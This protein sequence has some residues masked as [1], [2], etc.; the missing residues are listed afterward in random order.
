M[1]ADKRKLSP[2][3]QKFVDA[4]LVSFNSAKA[5]REAGYSEHTARTQG[6]RLLTNA[7]IREEIRERTEMTPDEVRA[8]QADIARGNIMD[9][10]EADASGIR[11]K[12]TATD[13]DGNVTPNP[14]AKLIRRITQR[15]SRHVSPKGGETETTA[16]EIEMYSAADALTKIGEM[17][18]LY[19]QR[20]VV[21]NPDGTP[22][23]PPKIVNIY[24]PH[25]G[26]ERTLPTTGN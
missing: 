13:A 10:I 12:L 5:A 21:E 17:H 19:R 25:N 22:I 8:R 16:F 2:Q 7:D 24:I 9:L 1:A 26:R 4:Y 18:G 23:E 15:T 6:S 20:Q 14:K 3:R 11:F